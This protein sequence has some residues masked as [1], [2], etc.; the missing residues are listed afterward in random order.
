MAKFNDKKK[1]NA[2]A[3]YLSGHKSV[4]FEIKVSRGAFDRI[5]TGYVV[6]AAKL[7]HG[8]TKH[9]EPWLHAAINS[10]VVAGEGRGYYIQRYLAVLITIYVWDTREVVEVIKLSRK[11]LKGKYLK[12]DQYGQDMLDLFENKA[13]VRD[14]NENLSGNAIDK[15]LNELMDFYSEFEEYDYRT[16]EE[17]RDKVNKQFNVSSPFDL[18]GDRRSERDKFYEEE[19]KLKSEAMK[20]CPEFK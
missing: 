11:D 10:V 14:N 9:T 18:T 8:I 20:N 7:K 4:A 15:A 1:K 3:R 17:I 12:E 16:D 6:A 2:I 13:F 5:Q 19:Y